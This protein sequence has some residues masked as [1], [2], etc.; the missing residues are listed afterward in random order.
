MACPD[1]APLGGVDEGAQDAQPGISP[2]PDGFRHGRHEFLPAVRVNTVVPG[3]GGNDELLRAVAFRN[4]RRHGQEDAVAEGDDGLFH[5]LRVVFSVRNVVRA[6]KKG[7]FQMGGNRGD[8]DNAVFYAETGRL[9]RGAFQL[10]FGVV[11]GVVKAE[12]QLHV[13]VFVRPVQGRAGVQ[14][15][16]E[17]DGGFH[18]FH[19]GF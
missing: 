2:Q 7:G 6:G 3:M 18:S 17:Q 16:A 1:D 10:P 14:A 11:G 13:V 8:V 15:P 5:Q 19:G 12:G 9:P 4:A